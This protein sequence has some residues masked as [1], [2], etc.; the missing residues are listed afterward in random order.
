MKL[1][2]NQS[3]LLAAAIL[4]AAVLLSNVANNELIISSI[5]LLGGIGTLVYT[6]FKDKRALH[7][8]ITKGNIYRKILVIIALA[9]LCFGV[10]TAV[11][12]VAYLWIG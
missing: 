4:L 5:M 9:A 8:L 11:G 3:L 2:I 7:C 6:F 1:T 10:G 12:K